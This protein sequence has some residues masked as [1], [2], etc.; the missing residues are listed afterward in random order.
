M[1]PATPEAC[2]LQQLPLELPRHL[3][4]APPC[5][6]PEGIGLTRGM[7]SPLRAQPQLAA[8][9]GGAWQELEAQL[10]NCLW[11]SSGGQD[12]FDTIIFGKNSCAS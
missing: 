6:S 11:G 3:L 8:P 2:E 4:V 12:F 5:E 7:P 1:L 9:K 10:S